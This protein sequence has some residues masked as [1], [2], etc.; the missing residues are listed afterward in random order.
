MAALA[1]TSALRL[2]S[3]LGTAPLQQNKSP[4]MF[5]GPGDSNCLVIF[6]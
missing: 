6:S 4:G 2:A 1:A 5:H 3:V